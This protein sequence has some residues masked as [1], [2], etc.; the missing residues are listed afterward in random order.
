MKRFYLH[1]RHRDGLILDEEGSLH[2][3]FAAAQRMAIAAARE[4][5]GADLLCGLIDLDQFIAILD[6]SGAVLGEV[7]FVTSFGLVG[8]DGF[9]AAVAPAPSEEVIIVP[10]LDEEPTPLGRSMPGPSEGMIAP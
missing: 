9:R 5:I 6:D 2:P 7:P 1:I 8:G 4:M 3:D 10:R